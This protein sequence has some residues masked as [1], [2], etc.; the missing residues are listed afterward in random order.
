MENPWTRDR[1]AFLKFSTYVAVGLLWLTSAAHAGADVIRYLVIDNFDAGRQISE[2]H[3]T[4]GSASSTGT[5]S[6][7]TDII[8]LE[9]E[10][11]LTV[12]ANQNARNASTGVDGGLFSVSNDPGVESTTVVTWDGVGSAGLGG[13]DLTSGLASN[14]FI[15]NVTN[16]ENVLA[17]ISVTD[18]SSN[19]STLAST[20][21]T[22]GDNLFFFT[23]FTGS[24]DFESVDSI[25]LKLTGPAAFDLAFD[26]FDAGTQGVPEPSSF[27]LL[28]VGFAVVGFG[29]FR[30]RRKT[31]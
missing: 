31:E 10:I 6:S 17:E 11:L 14:A 20:A 19:T 2:V 18:T 4:T 22:L 30:K 24:A 12:T 9:R 13:I 25:H 3:G 28:A 27:A 23:S 5:A 26:S 1:D 21:L 7:S 8:G 16:N 29:V 15:L